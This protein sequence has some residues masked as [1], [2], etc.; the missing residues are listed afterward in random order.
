MLISFPEYLS[1]LT[2]SFMEQE[3][4]FGT[5]Q[6]NRWSWTKEELQE[7]MFE[8]LTKGTSNRPVV[9]FVDA[10]DECGQDHAKCLLRYFKNLMD[11]AEHEEANDKDIR[12]VIRERLK[13]IQPEAKRQRIEKEILLKAQGGF[14]WMVLITAIVID[15]VTVGTKEEKLYEKI[16]TTPEALDELYNDILS[17]ATEAEKHQMTKLFQWVLFAER[18]PVCTRASGGACYR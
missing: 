5:Y 3:R 7:I 8:I 6:E 15:E 13:R 1:R 4:R 2:K 9:I 16:T 18:P 11:I 10:I 14:Q 17:G 12:L